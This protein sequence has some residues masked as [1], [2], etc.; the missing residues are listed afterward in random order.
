M[1]DT[2]LTAAQKLQMQDKGTKFQCHLD[3]EAGEPPMDDCVLDYGD[4]Y[5]C[6]HALKRNSRETCRFWL[7]AGQ[8]GITRLDLLRAIERHR[9]DV[10][11]NGPIKHAHDMELYR[12]AG[13][14]NLEYKGDAE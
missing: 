4:R 14:P 2:P 13:L 11:G 1:N 9:L 6:T 3:Q 5:G 7:P 12:S 8:P 10:W